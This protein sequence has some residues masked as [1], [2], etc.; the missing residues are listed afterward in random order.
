MKL[1]VVDYRGRNSEEIGS[2]FRKCPRPRPHVLPMTTALAIPW[3]HSQEPA[4]WFQR[5]WCILAVIRKRMLFVQSSRVYTSINQVTFRVY[6]HILLA[7]LST[8]SLLGRTVLPLKLDN[9]SAKSQQKGPYSVE[10]MLA[11]RL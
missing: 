8:N 7:K 1:V 11:I 5:A 6:L 9:M 2:F 4:K 10:W 3:P